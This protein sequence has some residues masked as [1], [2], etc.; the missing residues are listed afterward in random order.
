MSASTRNVLSVNVHHEFVGYTLDMHFTSTHGVTALLGPSGAGKSLTLRAIAGLLQPTRGCITLNERVL[1]DSA[2]RT[3][4]PTRDRQVGYVFQQYALFP[5]LSVAE[6]VAY[7]L[8]SWSRAARDE[9]VQEMLA[10]TELKDWASRHPRTLSGGQQQRVALARSL[11]PR[12][13]LL[14]LDE[15]LASLDTPLRAR[16]GA[17]LRALHER[18]G[19]PMVLVTHDPDEAARIAD[20]VVYVE[21]GRATAGA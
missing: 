9:R 18:T 1:F 15:P 5:H 10:L 7:G 6:N 14:L 20:S 13:S 21:A 3:N 12:P 19:I 11:A 17:E 2:T 4:V 8:H 16:L